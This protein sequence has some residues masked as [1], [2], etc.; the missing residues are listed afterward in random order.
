ML[1]CSMC[2]GDTEYAY[3]MLEQ[4]AMS[5]NTYPNYSNRASDLTDVRGH[6]LRMIT[7]MREFLHKVSEI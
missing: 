1:S 3:P 2:A 7:N 6:V 5:V 4:I